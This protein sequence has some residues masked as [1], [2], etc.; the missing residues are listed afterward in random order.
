MAGGPILPS[1]IYVGG[2]SGNLT[3]NFY[4]GTTA[5]GT[6][7]VANY[8][9]FESVQCVASLNSVGADALAILQFN[10]PPAG[11]MPTGTLKLRLLAMAN[12]STGIAKLDIIDAVTSPGTAIGAS[13]FTTEAG[14]PTISQNWAVAGVDILVENKV[15]L[16][17]APT[18]GQIVTVILAFRNSGWTLAQTSVWQAS[19]I[20]E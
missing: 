20:W 13:N 4:T 11:A 7:A 9:A 19:L 5:S 14:S 8:S 12:A 10:I 15:T 1:S 6:G 2:A 16:T 17:A 18:A 3:V